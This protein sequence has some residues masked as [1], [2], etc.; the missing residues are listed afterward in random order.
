MAFRGSAAVR[1][2]L[3]AVSALFGRV[4]RTLAATAL[5][6]AGRGAAHHGLV[7]RRPEVPMKLRLGPRALAKLRLKPRALAKLRL[8]PRALV[9]LRLWPLDRA[10]AV[11]LEVVTLGSR[12]EVVALRPCLESLLLRPV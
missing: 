11:R 10:A 12:L 9:K 3:P 1:Q 5:L 8:Q 2:P 7:R 6:R 4:V